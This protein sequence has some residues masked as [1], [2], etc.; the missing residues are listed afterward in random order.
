MKKVLYS[1]MSSLGSLVDSFMAD[2]PFHD[3][4]KKSTF[5]KFWPKIAGK[6]FENSSEISGFMSKNGKNILLVSCKSSVVTSEL[7]MF[8]NQILEKSNTFAN[9][10]GIKIDDINF[11]HKSWKN[12]NNSNQERLILDEN[13]YKE[14]LEGF[15]PDRVEIDKSEIESIKK[16]IEKNKALDS[17][18]RERLLNAIIY[19]LKVQKFL[20]KS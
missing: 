6:K 5:Y 4:V 1:D 7:T 10:L 8:K 15:D 20:R 14:K 17:A 2:T 12:A 3:E 13:P 11:S 18:Q 19:D 9:P 16:N